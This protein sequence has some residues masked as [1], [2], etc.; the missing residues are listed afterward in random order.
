MCSLIVAF[1]I[2]SVVIFFAELSLVENMRYPENDQVPR[3]GGRVLEENVNSDIALSVE[4]R[5]TQPHNGITLPPAPSMNEVY[6]ILQ[7]RKQSELRVEKSLRE[8]WWYL[9]KHLKSQQ[10]NNATLRRIRNQHI[11]LQWQYEQLDV[12][13]AGKFQLNWKYW[14]KNLSMELT[15]TMQKRIYHLQNPTD[16]KAKKLVCR[17]SKSCGFGCQIHHVSYCF[18]LAYAT[19]RMLILDSSN[20]RYSPSGWDAVF[21]PISSTCSK[22]PTGKLVQSTDIYVWCMTRTVRVL[23]N[24]LARV[25]IQCSDTG[26]LLMTARYNASRL[27]D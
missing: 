10:S 17:V 6:E 26:V 12:E 14:Q 27:P 2:L 21:Q 23:E 5:G 25:N 3:G 24:E 18:V 20:W 16:C 9:R 7:K 13:L 19:E 15:E 22:V 4:P 1:L 11:S 8:I